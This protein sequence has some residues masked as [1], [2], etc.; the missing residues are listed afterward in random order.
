[1]AAVASF[2]E[3]TSSDRY[4]GIRAWLTTT[5]HKRIGLLYLFVVLFWFTIAMLLGVFGYMVIEGANPLDALY[6]TVITLTTVGFEEAI[7]L[8]Y[9]GKIFTILLLL[10][11]VGRAGE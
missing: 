5:D 1:M 4:G 10:L 11:G 7:D 8:H 9:T 3:S 6:M 2:L